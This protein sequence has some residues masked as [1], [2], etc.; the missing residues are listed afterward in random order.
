MQ[1]DPLKKVRPG[2]Q[3]KIPAEAYNA[4][5]DAARLA[6][7]QQVLGA[8]PQAFL[9]QS[10]IAKVRNATAAAQ[11]R[12]AILG[13]GD[14]IIGPAA[15]LPE[16]QRQPTF[17]GSVPSMPGHER[18]FCVLLEPAAPN[19][20][21]PAVVAGVAPVQILVTGVA[22]GAAEPISGAT[23]AMRSVPHGPARVLWMETSGSPLRWALVG[24][25]EGDHEAIV[26]ITSNVPEGG[27]Y[28]GVVQKWIA[29]SWTSLFP[30]KVLDM[31][32]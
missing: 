29:G 16:F 31:N 25:D 26:M 12:F 13:L 2:D 18:R 11:P 28:P 7:G 14:P 23:S 21:V 4:F 1:G 3:L 32:E 9:R 5:V 22:F 8:E 10:T 24:I 20:V 19:A 15:N 17:F 27:Y 30:C 6:R